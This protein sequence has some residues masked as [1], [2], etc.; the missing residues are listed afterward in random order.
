MSPEQAIHP[1]TQSVLATVLMLFLGLG[2]SSL[3]AYV[4][5]DLARRVR[6]LR[7]RAGALWLLGA[8]SALAIGIWSSQVI[9]IAA[10]PPAFAFGYHGLGSLGVWAAA[11]VASLAGL[12]AV[13]GRVATPGRVGFGA[14]ALGVG[15]VG[16]HA[17]ALAPLGLVPGIDWQ[18]LPFVAA[19]AGAVGGCMMAL[20]AFFRGGDRTM[21]ATFGWQT[22]SAFV[23]GISMVATQQLILG[24]A[25]LDQQTG[26]LHADA[27]SSATLVLFASIGSCMVLG[28]GLLFSVLLRPQLPM[29]EAHML[30]IV[31]ATAAAEAIERHVPTRVAIKWPNDLFVGDRK[32]GGI[33]ME[34]AGEQDEVEWVVVGIGVNVNTEYSELPVVLRRTAT[35]L[36]MV[37]GG[38]VDRS[39]L[40]IGGGVKLGDERAVVAVQAD[41]LHAG[42]VVLPDR[43]AL[44]GGRKQVPGQAVAGVV[45]GRRAAKAAEM[46]GRAGRRGHVFHGQG[47]GL[48]F[49][50]PLLTPGGVSDTVR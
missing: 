20:G 12:G 34:V 36:K 1:E 46:T 29:S 3:A 44:V 23:F 18:I 33:L 32:V 45:G 2:V 43:A 10:E 47:A 21:P 4:A 28:V 13:S 16:T 15:A 38:A 39:D 50:V 37:T 35:S 6:V 27:V 42:L 25:G 17:L 40:F 49:P 8:A 7:T 31:A 30:T 5:L 41:G 9:G 11:L 24:A 14:F 22:T 48:G 19:F 26:S